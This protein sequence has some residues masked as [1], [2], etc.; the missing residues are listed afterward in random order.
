MQCCPLTEGDEPATLYH[1]VTIVARRDHGCDE[2]SE[3]IPRGAAYERVKG[4]WDGRWSTFKT[5]LSCVEIRNHFGCGRGWCHGTLW[6]DLE[7]NFFPGM[8]A[9]GPCM[10]GLSPEAKARLFERR[11]KWFEEIPAT[12]RAR[13]L[14]A[15]AAPPPEPPLPRP[16]DGA[17]MGG[18]DG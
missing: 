5:C 4:L 14:A 1:S 10:E 11:S 3:S 18:E 16:R 9:G 17:L 7:E 15:A 12:L 2:C 6:D 8:K 13:V